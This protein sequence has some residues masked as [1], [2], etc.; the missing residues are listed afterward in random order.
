M[1]GVFAVFMTVLAWTVGAFMRGY[2]VAMA[3][4]LIVLL[5]VVVVS[6]RS[7]VRESRPVTR[8]P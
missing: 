4:A 1:L 2:F 6:R 5:P 8:A 3:A 7:F